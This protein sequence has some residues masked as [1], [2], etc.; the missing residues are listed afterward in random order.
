MNWLD[1]AAGPRLILA[2][3]L[4]SIVAINP[5]REL[6][7]DDDGWAYARSVEHLLA[8]GRYQLDAW[9]AANMPVQIYGAAGLSRLFGYSL[10]LLRCFT[11]MLLIIGL[12]SFYALLRELR[13]TTQTATVLTI[14]LLASPL[15]IL[16]S[17]SFMS[18]I[19]FL[20]WM[21][22]ALWLYVRG[23]RRQSVKDMFLGSLA[24][25]CAIGTRQFGIALIGALV[26]SVLVSARERRPP[27]RLI[28]AGLAAPLLAAATQVYF[29]LAAPN[30]TQAFRLA[31][32]HRFL[33]HPAAVLLWELFWR[34][35][36]LLQ[37]TGMAMLPVLP[38]ALYASRRNGQRSPQRRSVIAITVLSAAAIIAALSMTSF[39]TARTAA[40]HRGVWEPL[41]L[42]WMLPAQFGR[43]RLLM[44]LL[45]L[46][47]I[48]GGAVL[49]ATC[50]QQIRRLWHTRR[51]SPELTLLAGT[52]IGLLALHLV[53]VQFNDTYIPA[54][55]PFGLIAFAQGQQR[56]TGDTAAE[57][58]NTTALAWSAALSF[59]II[60]AM[61]LYL[62]AEYAQLDA[63]WKGADAL[64]KSGVPPQKI[65]APL[66]WEKYHGAFD[67]W[68]AEGAPGFHPLSGDPPPGYDSFL[69]PFFAWLRNRDDNA[70]YRVGVLDGQLPAG[71][72]PVSS[73]R[74]RNIRL[75]QRSIW[76]LK[77]TP[78]R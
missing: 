12:F 18:D 36:V 8:T 20:A 59:T 66:A 48:V 53:Y 74:Y 77:R 51:L 26:L 10:S 32:Q 3:F 70:P 62:R 55:I 38:L 69:D 35:A 11:L 68:V 46:A 13:I 25:S 34:C 41:E 42:Y 4:V 52:A 17:F 61:S 16:L 72:E 19:Q 63:T 45:D 73:Y 27:V 5:F 30:I 9:S 50:F 71:W 75:Q 21:L 78:Q 40:L 39:L 14:A 7:G 15:T 33:H 67:E 58:G 29:G 64:V 22:L 47:G 23:L 1:R 60:V 65:A 44:H 76:S 24:A 2:A 49:A 6:L 56:E 31:E 54:F 57:A 28:V 43:S 37:Y